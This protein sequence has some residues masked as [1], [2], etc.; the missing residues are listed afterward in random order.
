MD[1]SIKLWKVLFWSILSQY[2]LGF[3]IHLISIRKDPNHSA[4]M[5]SR[6]K[7]SDQI[8][9]RYNIIIPFFYLK[10]ETL[11]FFYMLLLFLA[12]FT[13]F[14]CCLSFWDYLTNLKD[15]HYEFTDCKL[16][17]K[18]GRIEW[19]G[20]TDGKESKGERNAELEEE[21]EKEG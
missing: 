7:F 12:I 8:S 16:G 2:D 15:R 6:P 5:S 3:W 10:H 4:I 19:K 14:V 13:D 1:C 20:K 9:C 18:I 21:K 17:E 11:R